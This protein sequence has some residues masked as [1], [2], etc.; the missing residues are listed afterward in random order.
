MSCLPIQYFFTKSLKKFIPI[1]ISVLK[2]NK[3]SGCITY[4]YAS[5]SA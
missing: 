1:I 5:S 3:L 2:M 4:A